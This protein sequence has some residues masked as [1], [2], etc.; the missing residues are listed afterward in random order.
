MRASVPSDSELDLNSLIPDDLDQFPNLIGRFEGGQDFRGEFV[1]ESKTASG[2]VTCIKRPVCLQLELSNVQVHV[3]ATESSNSTIVA[4]AIF[5]N[6]PLGCIFLRG[7]SHNDLR[8][9]AYALATIE[10]SACQSEAFIELSHGDV[11]GM[12]IELDGHAFSEIRDSLKRQSYARLLIETELWVLNDDKIYFYEERL[13]SPK[14]KLQ[15]FSEAR[16]LNFPIEELQSVVLCRH[17]GEEIYLDDGVSKRPS[18]SRNRS[19]IRAFV[20]LVEVIV[21]IA[22]IYYNLH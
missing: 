5:R 12:K 15:Q 22:F 14:I 20:I 6:R 19:I 8:E 16:M 17:V 10:I 9:Y 1:D 2:P 21:G 18:S 4:A 13:S 7:H 11:L 3:G